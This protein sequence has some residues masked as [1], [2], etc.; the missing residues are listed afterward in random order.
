MNLLYPFR[1]YFGNKLD[2]SLP[3]SAD[4]IPAYAVCFEQAVA[5]TSS[6]GFSS[7]ASILNLGD[8]LDT[9]GKFAI[10]IFKAI[11]IDQ[12]KSA[13]QCLK[14]CH[15]MAPLFEQ[16]LGCKVWP[17]VGQI[18]KDNHAI[19]SPSWNN[20]K[21]W[22]SEGFHIKDFEGRRGFNLHAWLT[23]ESGEIIDPT[24]LSTLAAFFGGECAQFAGGIVWGR[25][26]KVLNNHRY[27]P[28][29]VGQKFIDAIANR[30]GLPLL[31]NNAA[32][33]ALYPVIAILGHDAN[34]KTL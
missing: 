27:F 12:S 24:Y 19:F 21:R 17:T 7:N 5:F 29:A 9:E 2:F 4:E 34:P 32:E 11:N 13:M 18:W 6:C 10:P 33:L 25:D 23:I 30:S 1:N 26:P 28:M 16:Q 31:A 14:W 20:L 22:S 8:V 3:K 15:F